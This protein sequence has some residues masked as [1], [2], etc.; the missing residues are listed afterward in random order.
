MADKLLQRTERFL[1][2]LEEERLSAKLHNESNSL[3]TEVVALI[4]EYY[5]E[6]RLM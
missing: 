5:S 4:G 3:L 6:S 2:E 1:K